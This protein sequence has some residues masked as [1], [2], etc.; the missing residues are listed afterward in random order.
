MAFTK[1]F[2]QNEKNGTVNQFVHLLQS[3]LKSGDFSQAKAFDL[4]E[5]RDNHA[6]SAQKFQYLQQC[7]L[8]TR[9]AWLDVTT[10]RNY[11]ER[12]KRQILDQLVLSLGEN[13]VITNAQREALLSNLDLD[14]TITTGKGVVKCYDFNTMS[15]SIITQWEKDIVLDDWES[16]IVYGSVGKNQ[17]HIY[18]TVINLLEAVYKCGLTQTQFAE[19]LLL[20][21]NKYIPRYSFILAGNK[22]KIEPH[23]VF[24]RV[25]R[26]LQSSKDIHKIER[27]ISKI[28]RKVGANITLPITTFERLNMELLTHRF[29][30]ATE[31][32]LAKKNARQLKSVIS[33]FVSDQVKAEI[34]EFRKTK[35]NTG[36]DYTVEQMITHINFCEDMD[37]NNRPKV[38]KTIGAKSLD[39]QCYAA[40]RVGGAEAEAKSDGPGNYQ[41]KAVQSHI[42]STQKA[43]PGPTKPANH[44]NPHAKSVPSSGNQGQGNTYSPGRGGH[45]ARSNH[46]T[47]GRGNGRGRGG[48]GRGR[49]RSRSRYRDNQQNTSDQSQ[50]DKTFTPQN[51]RQNTGCKICG[52]KCGSAN[53]KCN[54]M[55]NVAKTSHPCTVCSALGFAGHHQVNDKCLE[56]HVKHDIRKEN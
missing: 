42:Q 56:I 38:D 41:T 20:I 8:T 47:R 1:Q 14:P 7:Y 17:V 44:N 37:E 50:A 52:R 11:F 36:E 49:Q 18:K 31:E 5:F 27:A 54:L 9:W 12:Q 19:I 15:Y 45:G 53:G 2:F 10:A 3:G 29:P 39:V 35:D 28:T 40:Q 13:D 43:L 25:I 23:V 51:G 26:I 48:R 21:I 34:K 6:L 46:Y 4:P 33:D 32:E 24:Q 55:P 30:F 22:Q 16:Y